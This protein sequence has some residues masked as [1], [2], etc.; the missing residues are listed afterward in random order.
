MVNLWKVKEQL[1]K[2]KLHGK[3]CVVFH[4]NPPTSTLTPTLALRER[5]QNHI[6]GQ[7][8]SSI[9]HNWPIPGRGHDKKH[10]DQPFCEMRCWA[11]MSSVTPVWSYVSVWSAPF[12][13]WLL[14]WTRGHMTSQTNAWLI[15]PA[16][17]CITKCLVDD[18]VRFDQ[19][20]INRSKFWQKFS[21]QIYLQ[22]Q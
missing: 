6:I 5:T 18:G 15:I 22:P 20:Y 19:W 2:W 1:V 4:K 12:M 7:P 8:E 21:F 9:N 11:G 17:S 14:S 13:L 3:L 16:Q 10:I